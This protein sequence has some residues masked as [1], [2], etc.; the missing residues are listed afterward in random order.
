MF[1]EIISIWA[2]AFPRVVYFPELD[3]HYFPFALN[4][5]KEQSTFKTVQLQYYEHLKHD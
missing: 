4:Y 3:M 1:L 2:L 5:N